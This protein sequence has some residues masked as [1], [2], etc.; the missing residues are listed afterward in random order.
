MIYVEKLFAGRSR[1]I[2]VILSECVG[3]VL[4]GCDVIWPGVSR[5]RF[6]PQEWKKRVGVGHNASKAIVKERAIHL[7]WEPDSDHASDAGCIA[8]AGWIE[9]EKGQY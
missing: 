9:N 1:K 8:S 4:M 7:G 5:N 2:T 3:S 6:V